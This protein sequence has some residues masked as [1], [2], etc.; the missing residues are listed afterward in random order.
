MMDLSDGLGSDLPKLAQESGC[1]FRIIPESLPVHQESSM[2]EAIRDGE[3]YELLISV[4]PRQWP[5]LQRRWERTFPKLP[6]AVIGALLDHHASS[7][8]LP[9]GHDHLH[10]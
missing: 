3:D 10:P 7:T 9:S 1:S 8:L 2:Q 4:S 5:D 6:L